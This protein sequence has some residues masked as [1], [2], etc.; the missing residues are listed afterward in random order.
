MKASFWRWLVFLALVPS[1]SSAVHAA[2]ASLDDLLARSA[3]PPG[4]VFEIVDRDP[5]A[6]EV[7]LP[8]VKQ[9][10]Q[11]LKARFPDV[12]MA[13]VTHGQEMFALQSG[14]RESNAAIHQ[15][16]QSLSRDDGIPVHVCETYAGRRGLATEDFPAYIDVA[17]TGPTQIR[18]Y[19]ALDYVRL[20]VPRS[21]ALAPR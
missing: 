10:S 20:V 9:A 7:A 15:L 13:L 8:W 6:L 11:Q 14:T 16:A 19:E 21:A 5:R 18:N 4:V 1:M 12:P 3:A 17:P 2:A